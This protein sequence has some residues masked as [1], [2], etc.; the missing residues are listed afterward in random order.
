MDVRAVAEAVA[1]GRARCGARPGDQHPG[2]RPVS[3]IL[4]GDAP[5][6]ARVIGF[7]RWLLNPPMKLLA[8]VGLV[9]GQVVLETR[10]RRTGRPRRT[11]VGARRE[12][13]TVWIV[14]EQGRR[15]AWVRNLDADPCVRVRHRARWQQARAVIV[16]DDDPRARLTT[17]HRPHTLDSSKSSAPSWQPSG[18]TSEHRHDREPASALRPTTRRPRSGRFNARGVG[19]PP[20]NRELPAPG[21]GDANSLGTRSSSTREGAS[22]PVTARSSRLKPVG[23]R[24]F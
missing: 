22:P 3:S 18:S 17:W 21:A 8:W 2:C 9:P 11:V 7:Q 15:A 13:H 5:R 6:R 20:K 16:D 14:A 19:E 4:N 1:A 10:G 23:W 12:Q 24:A